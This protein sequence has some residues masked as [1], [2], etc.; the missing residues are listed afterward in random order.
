ML[1]EKSQETAYYMSSSRGEVWA[2]MN[3]LV[4]QS[5]VSALFTLDEVQKKT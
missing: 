3:H 5:L 2:N 4:P 1:R